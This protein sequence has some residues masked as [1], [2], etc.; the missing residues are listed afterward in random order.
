MGENG[1]IF[2]VV[3]GPVVVSQASVILFSNKYVFGSGWP[4]PNAPAFGLADGEH[5]LYYSR[6]PHYMNC[7]VNAIDHPE[8]HGWYDV[9][10]FST[11]GERSLAS[12]LAGGG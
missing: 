7:Q 11:E 9:I 2:H 1:A 3:T 6:C 4:K 12:L 8:L 5:E 10:I